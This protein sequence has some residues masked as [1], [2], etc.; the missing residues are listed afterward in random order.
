M[1]SRARASRKLAAKTARLWQA[2]AQARIDVSAHNR[3][4][5]PPRFEHLVSQAVSRAQCDH[6]L[7]RAWAARLFDPSGDPMASGLGAHTLYHRKTWE[8]AYILQAIHQYGRLGDGRTACGFGVGGEPIPATLAAHGVSVLATDQPASAAEMNTWASTGQWMRGIES[9]Y[10]PHIVA[11]AELTRLVT[12]RPVDLTAMPA[13]LGMFDIVWSSCVIEHLGSPEQGL[14]F[15]RDSL[16]LLKPGGVAVH[17]TELELVPHPVSVDYGH[18]AIYS[19]D[20][21]CALERQLVADGFETTFNPYVCMD[22]PEDRFVSMALTRNGFPLLD[23]AH[24]KV[25]LRDS[26]TTSFGILARRPE[27][28]APS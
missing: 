17:T 25:A 2:D 24:L 14:A 4:G 28:R 22:T 11:D 21:L 10:R 26:V 6:P 20:D 9:L 8:Y 7:Y 5:Q 3:A 23:R 13:D 15:V 18:C 12:T 27:A 16:D 19:L 1:W